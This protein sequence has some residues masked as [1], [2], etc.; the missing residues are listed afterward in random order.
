M[1]VWCIFDSSVGKESVCNTGDP[2]SIPGSRRSAGE[3]IG[4]PLQYSWASRVA[5]LVKNLPAMWKIWFDPWIGK[6]PWRRARLP[7]PVFW[8]GEFH[9]LYKVCEVTKSQAQ[10]SDFHSLR[11]TVY[12]II[13]TLPWAQAWPSYQ[14]AFWLSRLCPFGSRLYIPYYVFVPLSAYKHVKL[15]RR[16]SALFINF[17]IFYTILNVTHHLQLL[18][19]SDYVPHSAESILELILYPIVCTSH[20]PPLN[21]PSVHSPWVT[22]HQL[23]LWICESASFLTPW[24]ESY[25][26]PR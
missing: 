9:G 20:S 16:W 10:L 24:K 15:Q 12:S 2:G 21:R 14:F 17:F 19:N 11:S 22:N 25:D 23:V 5:Q 13:Q 7:T 4:H 26:Q 18:Q 8:P 6:I 1:N 3:G